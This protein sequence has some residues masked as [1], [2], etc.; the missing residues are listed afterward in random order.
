MVVSPIR[1]GGIETDETTT[2]HIWIWKS[3]RHCA[4]TAAT[5]QTDMCMIGVV[6]DKC[7]PAGPGR[8]GGISH[9]ENIAVSGFM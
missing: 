8:A 5:S 4:Y 7:E 6:L 2:P 3:I 9:C 1:Y